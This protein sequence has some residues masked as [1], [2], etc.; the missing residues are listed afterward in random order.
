MFAFSIGSTQSQ[1][2]VSTLEPRIA[3]ERELSGGQNHIYQ[4]SL[5]KDQYA[6]VNVEQRGIDVVVHLFGTDEK[7]VADFDSELRLKGAENV[8]LIAE[9]AGVYKLEV[10]SKNKADPIGRYAI[11]LAELK[12]ATDRDRSLDEARKLIK[13]SDKLV[14]QDK[15]SEARPLAERALLIRE[16]TLEAITPT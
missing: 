9:T 11:Q 15:A 12:P 5:S 13:E 6:S 2:E 3:I 8:E 1:Q 4:F 14:S 7:Q 10:E 16:E